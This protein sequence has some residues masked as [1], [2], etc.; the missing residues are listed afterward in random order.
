[1]STFG[2]MILTLCRGAAERQQRLDPGASA[3][4]PTTAA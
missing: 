4:A 1:V 3:T 2:L